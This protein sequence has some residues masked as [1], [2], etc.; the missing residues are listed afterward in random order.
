MS[1]T[2]SI[3]ERSPGRAPRWVWVLLVVSLAGNLLLIGLIAGA[4]WFRYQ[5][6][7]SSL[8]SGGAFGFIR[9]L[10]KERR[11]A[12]RQASREQIA[13]L[14]PLWQ[15][16]REARR[17]AQRALTAEPFDAAA[18]LTAQRRVVDSEHAARS[19]GAQI[20]ADAAAKLTPDERRRMA[21][22]AD[23]HGGRDRER[24]RD[25]ER[26]GDLR[27]GAD[28]ELQRVPPPSPR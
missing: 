24:D 9:A 1:Q 28:G 17:E 11:D 15:T 18:F 6:G 19:A 20:L 27:Q 14:R 10:P 26:N 16:V 21:R 5:V 13:G 8:G 7:G 2:I 25:R 12:L 23:R 3:P 4:A 22:W